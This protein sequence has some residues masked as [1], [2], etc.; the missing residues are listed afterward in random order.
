MDAIAATSYAQLSRGYTMR[1]EDNLSLSQNPKTAITP[2]PFTSRDGLILDVDPNP[3]VPA[4]GLPNL[5]APGK[6]FNA[7]PLCYCL[8][9]IAV[10][11]TWIAVTAAVPLWSVW[12]SR[13]FFIYMQFF[14]VVSL[15]FFVNVF[16]LMADLIIRIWGAKNVFRIAHFISWAGCSTLLYVWALYEFPKSADSM[17]Q[18]VLACVFSGLIG[19]CSAAGYFAVSFSCKNMSMQSKH[20]CTQGFWYGVVI[21][22]ATLL[23]SGFTQVYGNSISYYYWY[24][25]GGTVSL[26]GISAHLIEFST[27]FC[28]GLEGLE[29]E[30]ALRYCNRVLRVLDKNAANVDDSGVNDRSIIRVAL[31]LQ[32]PLF[33]CSMSFVATSFVLVHF[34]Y[35]QSC[36]PNMPTVW[37]YVMLFGIHM[38][39]QISALSQNGLLPFSIRLSV[40][41]AFI[42]FIRVALALLMILF[43]RDVCCPLFSLQRCFGS[44]SSPF[45]PPWVDDRWMTLILL[46]FFTLGSFTCSQLIKITCS[47][48]RESDRDLCCK[49][50][51]LQLPTPVTVIPVHKSLVFFPAPRWLRRTDCWLYTWFYPLFSVRLLDILPSFV[52]G[53]CN[54][55]NSLTLTP[56]SRFWN[57][58]PP[59]YFGVSFRIGRPGFCLT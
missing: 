39:Q 29:K 43:I 6:H 58:F 19:F 34:P 27:T 50:L 5:V 9:S 17:S 20:S 45:Q 21:N 57:M 30:L 7:L 35:L 15:F 14:Y 46:S 16:E 59:S 24:Y 2:L 25:V 40:F 49:T 48:V 42:E 3:I 31:N 56:H 11:T 18:R 33:I 47:R 23:L 54:S 1:D 13:D 10:S 12:F 55:Y 53:G 8:L 52:P 38:G 44:L 51:V 41:C 36:S 22:I 26:F 37:V 32:F 4:P 28:K